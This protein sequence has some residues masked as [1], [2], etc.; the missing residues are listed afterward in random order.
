M[1]PIKLNLLSPEKRKYLRRLVYFQF[2]K[3]ALIS[4]VFVFCI[5]GITLL[6]GQWVLQEYANDISTGFTLT[7]G[8]HDNKNEQIREVN[9]VIKNIDAL[10]KTH[11]LWSPLITDFANSIPNEVSVNSVIFDKE[12]I[13][14]SGLARTRD[15]LLKMQADLNALDFV[16]RTDI[17]LSQLT[18]KENISFSITSHLK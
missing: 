11:Q 12:K 4:V 7:I 18:E 10:Q 1:Y 13:I 16:E 5:S 6:G 3:N 15:D 17:P 2:I 9:E 14:L 8:L